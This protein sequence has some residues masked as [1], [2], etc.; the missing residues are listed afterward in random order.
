MIRGVRPRLELRDRRHTR[1]LTQKA[2]ADELGVSPSAVRSWE[3]GTRDPRLRVRSDIAEVLSVSITEVNRWFGNGVEVAEG[4]VPEWLGT[5]AGFEQGASDLWAY[6]PIVAP[7]LVQTAAYAAA[8]Q[9]GAPGPPSEPEIEEAVQ[10][11]LARQAALTRPDPLRLHLIIDESVLYRPV[12]GAKVM[13]EQL[14]HLLDLSTVPHITLQI[15]PLDSGVYSAAFGY[16]AVLSTAATGGPYMAHVLDRGG[17]HYLDR[18][19]DVERHVRLF[20]HLLT[21]A[22]SVHDTNVLIEETLRSRYQ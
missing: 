12:G 6:E 17:N 13:A 1:G 21:A 15:L 10:H 8:V 3:N 2:L 7:G 19:E 20:H 11:R 5:F 16:F 22:L 9:R 14:T 4:V 18:R